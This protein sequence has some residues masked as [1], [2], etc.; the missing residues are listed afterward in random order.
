MADAAPLLAAF[1]DKVFVGSGAENHGELL[2][3]EFPGGRLL[4]R[5]NFLASEIGRIALR[6]LPPAGS[7]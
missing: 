2:R 3:R 4:Y 5:S 7:T 6:A 1:P